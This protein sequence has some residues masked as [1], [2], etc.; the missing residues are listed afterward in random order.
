MRAARGVL[1]AVV[2]LLGLLPAAA[3]A[4]TDPSVDRMRADIAALVAGGPREAGTAA[5][6]AAFDLVVARLAAIGRTAAGHDVPL[7]NG[8]T[9]RNRWVSFG[10]GP[11]EI[12]LGAHVDS[13][14]TSPGADDN[15]S[16]TAVL[17]ELARRFASG[18]LP[19]PSGTTVTLVWFGAEERL[20]GRPANDHHFGS[21]QFASERAA[22]GLHP[23]WMLSVD[24]VG[25]GPTPL[26]VW[27]DGTSITAAH[28]LAAAATAAGVPAALSARGDI[29]DHEA[30]G[31]RGTPAAMLWRPENP[32]YHGPGD[33]VVEDGALSASLRTVERFVEI[34]GHPFRSNLGM[35]H[36]L[37]ADLLA[38]RPDVAGAAARVAPLDRGQGTAGQVAADL[39]ASSEWAS[40]VAPVGRLYRA[41]FGRD[42]DLPGLR[43]WT[44][45]LRTGTSLT[46][47]AGGFVAASEFRDRYGDLDDGAFVDQLYRNVLGRG[48]D[49]TGRA[50]WV[51][52]LRCCATRAQVLVGFSE[53]LEHRG[54]TAVTL[55]IGLAYIGLLRRT[56]DPAGLAAWSRHSTA[57][58]LAGL[59][60]SAEL[61]HR[62][63]P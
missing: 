51:E 9:S 55:P 4:T 40:I 60:G 32:G 63:P 56:V 18:E 7:P 58:M 37:Y 43:G 45:V 38:R 21:R 41:A 42:A 15:A 17:L 61:R 26:S 31:R 2:L 50:A 13:V 1:A 52:Q 54:R 48:P 5:E 44:G 22:L 49:P 12:L 36:E 27:F 16:G 30:F 62:F 53:S 46:T 3:P 35:V 25:F 59:V 11:V 57:E 10:T 8:R 14:P 33:T 34:A 28:V 47:V 29:S 24:M 23:H 20:A 19:V 6:R 39:V